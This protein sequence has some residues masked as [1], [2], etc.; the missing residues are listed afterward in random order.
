MF[1]SRS[2]QKINKCI[3]RI[4]GKK[5]SALDELFEL[6]KKDLYV[7]ACS[8]L[9]DKS[10]AEDVLSDS[11]L[12]V[13]KSAASF[14]RKQN[15]YNWLYEIVKNTALNQ[16]KKDKLRDGEPLT[17]TNQPNYEFVESLCN[18]LM[19]EQALNGLSEE[20]KR[21]IYEYFFER[22]TVK[23]IA[24]RIGKPKTT[25][26]DLIKRL[27][28]KM[29]NRLEAPEQKSHKGVYKTGGQNEE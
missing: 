28:E 4:A 14:D 5:E 21:I 26:Y 13:V 25:T 7:V 11:Y 3:I 9:Y 16:N 12:K 2:I 19:V 20:E 8:Y 23:E 24:D 18:R 1:N 10:K 17:E 29:K 6:T 15:G 22:K 27:L